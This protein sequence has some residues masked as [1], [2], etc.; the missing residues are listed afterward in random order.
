MEQEQ[1][2]ELQSS[3]N[4][5]FHFWK[6]FEKNFLSFS[7]LAAGVMISSSALYVNNAGIQKGTAN[8]PSGP[9]VI[10]DVSVDDDV[11]MGNPNAKV[12]IIEFS[13]YQCPFCRVF[14]RDTLSQIKKEYIDTGKVKFVYRDFPL[15]FHPMAVV[16]AQA[17]ECAG[18]QEKYWEMQDKIFREQEKLGQ[19]TVSYSVENLKKWAT[20]VGL[21]QNLFNQCLD[22]EKYKNEVEK[23]FNDGSAAGVSGTPTTYVNGRKLVGAQ[24][25]SAF[26]AVIDEELKK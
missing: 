6:F 4:S 13:D 16:S 11:V 19:G 18:D 25:F 2:T 21:N 9:E 8:I 23:D 12:A 1:Q 7:I 20:E 17:A 22:S 5:K 26:K 3:E 14:W 15:A 24:P 10:A